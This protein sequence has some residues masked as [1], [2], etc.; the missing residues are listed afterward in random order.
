M[1]ENKNH[2]EYINKKKELGFYY[3]KE[4]RNHDKLANFDEHE[5]STISFIFS[6]L[7]NLIALHNEREEG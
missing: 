7:Q 3:L 4:F 6:S 1:W 2:I 5:Q